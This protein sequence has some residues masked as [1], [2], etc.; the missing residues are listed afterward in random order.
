[1]FDPFTAFTAD[2]LSAAFD[3]VRADPDPVPPNMDMQLM[4]VFINAAENGNPGMNRS[5]FAWAFAL[6][7]AAEQFRNERTS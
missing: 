4:S 3:S 2:D 6:G 1:M 5:M 7:V